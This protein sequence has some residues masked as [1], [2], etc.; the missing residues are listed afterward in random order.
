[1]RADNDIE[2]AGA[3]SLSPSLVRMERLTELDLSCTLLHR[4]QLRCERV[5]AN[6]GC[7][8]MMSRVA[9]W[10]GCAL[11]YRG[12]WRVV[13]LATGRAEKRRCVQAIRSEQLGQRRWHRVS[14]G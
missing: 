7:A 3:A 1:V 5:A 4:R 12:W 14:E 9:G 2:A 10:G 6:A 8:W 13:G 11:G